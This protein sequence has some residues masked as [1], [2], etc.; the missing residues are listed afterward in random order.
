MKI[1]EYRESDA[2]EKAEVHRRS[3]R[4]I[5]RDDYSRDEIEVW[6]D[7]EVEDDPLPDKKVRYVATENGKIVGF[8]DYDRE[9]GEITGLY[10]HPDYTGEGVGQQLLGEVEKDARE[11]NL[12]NLMCSS[13]VTAKRFYRRNGYEVIRQETHEIENQDLKVYTMKKQL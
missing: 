12:D 1:R 7:V 6:S 10:V 3:I 13:T 11:H 2:K 8:G 5:A 9:G 4:E